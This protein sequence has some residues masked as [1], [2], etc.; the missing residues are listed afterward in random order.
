M[1]D[2]IFD[3]FPSSS[4]IADLPNLSIF[5]TRGFYSQEDGFGCTYLV[6]N[7]WRAS[8]LSIGDKNVVPLSQAKGEVYLPYYGIRTGAEYAESNSAILASIRNIQFGSLIKLPAGHFYFKDTIS[9]V[10]NQLKLRG[11]SIVGFTTDVNSAGLTFLHFPYLTEGQAAIEGGFSAISD[12]IFHGNPNTY[13]LK[14]DRT[15][16]GIAPDELVTETNKAV[17]YGIRILYQIDIQNCSFRY[18][19]YGIYSDN[20]N[21]SLHNIIGFN[22]HTVVSVGNDAK[23]SKLYGFNIMK[24]L[25]I[26]GSICSAVTVRGDSI[27]EHLVHIV[28]GTS[29]HLTDL[30]ADYCLK[31]ILHMGSGNWESIEAL[32]VNGIHGR[33]GVYRAYD[34][35]VGSSPTVADITTSA[36]VKEYPYISIDEKC[37]V[38]SAK[39]VIQEYGNK[40]PIDVSSNY[41]TPSVLLVAGASTTVQG[42]SITLIG[43][44]LAGDDTEPFSPAWI[45]KRVRSFSANARNLE[46]S[47]ETAYDKIYLRRSGNNVTYRKVVTEPIS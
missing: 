12:I 8:A 16:T 5:T 1:P 7:G 28:S 23:I 32:Y 38:W 26:R 15:K 9:F 42:V 17:T 29:I 45:A 21:V 14:I 6:T 39:I 36:H 24:V 19:Y 35:T 10:G 3:T 27:G 30:D 37:S 43:R 31:S 18:F 4:V 46:V 11:V 2:M 40:N 47:I 33:H 41:L 13:N 34:K 20:A 22:C 25:Q 44:G